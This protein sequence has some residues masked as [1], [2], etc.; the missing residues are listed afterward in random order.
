[1]LS[2]LPRLIGHRGAKESA[3]ENT[4]ASIREAARQGAS[5]VELDV[6][7]TRDGRPVIIHD[8]TL[9]RT[10]TGRGP[11]PLLDLEALRQ[12]DAGSWFDP[13]FAD[14]RVPALEEAVELIRD[15]GLSLNLEIK[16][17]PGQDVATA[18]AALAV[19]RRLWPAGRPL[20]LSSFEV[21]SLE[22]ARDLWPEIP[23]GYLIWKE[24]ADWAAI[25]DR[26][27]AATIN[28]NHEWQ[29]PET[30]AAYRATG[31]PVLAYTVN[32][33]ERAR[34]MFAWGVTGVFTDAPGRLAAELAGEP[35]GGSGTELGAE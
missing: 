26:V 24:P 21:P 5:W 25:A 12:L 7:L 15:L 30:V 9:D 10:T 1:M 14:E 22:V 3:P 17:Y 33:A 6:M 32:D 8:D 18:E 31:R 19:L 27:G 16:P 20:L 29:T 28:V 4:L 35:N 13:R 34:T 2:T 23:R 11:V